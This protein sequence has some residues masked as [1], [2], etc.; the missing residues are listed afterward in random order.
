VN[1]RYRSL[2][3]PWNALFPF[4][5]HL[6][7]IMVESP[8]VVLSLADRTLIEVRWQVPLV[9]FRAFYTLVEDW[10]VENLNSW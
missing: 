4:V 8:L 6:D 2:L 1:L 3:K 5:Y 7:P 9:R 10:N